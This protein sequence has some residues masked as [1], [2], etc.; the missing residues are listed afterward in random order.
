M[1]DLLRVWDALLSDSDEGRQLLLYVA[2]ARLILVREEILRSDF[3]ACGTLLQEG[4]IGG[5]NVQ[6]MLS[7][8]KR[9]RSEQLE[10]DSHTARRSGLM[11]KLF[12]GSR[13]QKK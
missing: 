6:H 7:L 8:A 1:P 2:V 13:E 10:A 12:K 5:V 11:S 3:Q 9:L 4:P